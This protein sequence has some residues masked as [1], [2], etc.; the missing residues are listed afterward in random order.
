VP[1]HPRLW[2]YFDTASRH[3]RRYT[4]H[5]LRELFTQADFRVDYMSQYMMSIFPL[6]WLGRRRAEMAEAG[7]CHEPERAD[8]LADKELRIVPLVNELLAGVLSLEALAIVR[9]WRLPI[10]TS[11]L[12]VASMDDD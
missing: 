9:G 2:S 4:P 10:G 5:G 11:L 12:V 6:V 7:S 8:R 3:R 1:A